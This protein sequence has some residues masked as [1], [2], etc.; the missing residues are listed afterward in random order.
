MKTPRRIRIGGSFLVT[1]LLLASCGDDV[2]PM[3][4][5]WSEVTEDGSKGMVITF[6]GYSDKLA[7]HLKPREGGGHG[8]ATGELTYDYDAES[9]ALTVRALLLGPQGPAVW[10]GVVASDAFDLAA[11]DHRLR[12]QRGGSAGH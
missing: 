7:V 9:G 4:G 6:D 12:F 11:A 5:N 1:A 8:H 3:A 10:R 2:G